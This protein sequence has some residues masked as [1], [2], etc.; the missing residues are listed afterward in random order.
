MSMASISEARGMDPRLF[1]AATQ[2]SVRSLRKL[3][4]ADVKILNSTTPQ[5]NTALHLAA[6]HGHADFARE[7][8]SVSEE[9]LAARNADGDTPLHLAAKTGKLKVAD[10]FVR[11]AQEWPVDPNTE[12]DT[13]FKSPLSM[14]NLAG[15]NPLHEAVAHHKSDVALMLLHVDPNRAHDLNGYDESP[16]DMAAREGLVQIVHKILDLAWVPMQFIPSPSGTALHQ[17]VRSGHNRIMEIL[18]EK[19]EHLIDIADSSGNNALH[20]AAQEDHPRPVEI[21]LNKHTGL[22]Y[23]RNGD[24]QTPLHVAA[25]H[26]STGAIKALLRR[27]PDVA[28][29]LDSDGR[30]A[31]HVAVTS[32]KTNALRCLL[33]HARPA[34]LLNRA[35]AK[36]NTPLHLAA[37][38]SH[39]QSALLLLKDSRVDPCI[40]NQDGHTARSL[41]EVRSAHGHATYRL[42]DGEDDHPP[43]SVVEIKSAA[44]EMD[45]YEMY[46]WKQLKHAEA[47]RNRKEQLP[48]VTLISRDR[49]NYKQYSD[50]IIE[51]YLLVATVIA[52]ATFAATF[53]M[54]GGY[55]QTK[56]DTLHGHNTA[57]KIF[58]ISNT[59]ASCSSVVIIICS[60]W[61]WQ[62]P[63]K[64]K[65]RLILWGQRLTI[66]ACLGMLLSLVTAVYITVAPTSRWPAYV[67]IAIVA[68][69]PG[70]V[71]LI[72][73]GEIFVVPL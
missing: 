71:V 66:I 2:G 40:R 70:A 3:V 6:L 29:M 25:Q 22:A 45:A 60:V 15:N 17:A 56:G 65:A 19:R 72:L 64:F 28:E 23:M 49:T 12:E 52:T 4:V 69:S 18:L 57:F 34:A 62:D 55:D 36:G 67:V 8:L 37:E 24:G 73:G 9:M 59:I 47:V 26:G 68:S 41:L 14:R 30:T 21:L 16:L 38:M 10:L 50:R 35:D 39:V 31:F 11:L 51:T 58:V 13:P 46:L 32:G 48:P 42:A 44:G 7:V 33:R 20:C 43:H 63:D 61:A 5:H 27:C 53:T 1:K 54:P